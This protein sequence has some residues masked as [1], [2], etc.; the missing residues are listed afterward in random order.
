MLLSV[1]EGLVL[2]SLQPT[3]LNDALCSS[4][5][6]CPDWTK[7]AN[8]RNLSST[9]AISRTYWAQQLLA[10]EMT[11]LFDRGN[12]LRDDNEKSERFTHRWHGWF[13]DRCNYQ[14]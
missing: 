6:E 14:L 13:C 3:A 4:S 2:H 7:L 5:I 1:V 12:L 9:Q 11:L 8:T 10:L